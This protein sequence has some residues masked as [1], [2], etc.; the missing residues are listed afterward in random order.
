MIFRNSMLIA[1]LF[2]TAC[3]AKH[4]HYAPNAVATKSQAIKIIE[5][6]FFEQP[7]KS[8]PQNVFITDDF[9]GL[10]KGIRSKSRG[11]GVGLSNNMNLGIGLGSSKTLSKEINQRIYFN[12]I[13]I[14]KLYTKKRRYIVQIRSDLGKTIINVYTQNENKAKKFIDSI[15][16]FINNTKQL[17]E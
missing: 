1:V 13:Q 6:V 15:L 9:I 10:A 7:I 16:Y 8:L 17:G 3:S 14:P 12:S 2:L 11:F 4:I 5:Q